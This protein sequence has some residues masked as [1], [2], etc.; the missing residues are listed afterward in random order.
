MNI[1]NII[2]RVFLKERASS[3]EYIKYL[4][5]LGVEIGEDCDIFVPTKTVIDV[6]NPWMLKI[7]DY[8]RITDGVK[9]LTHDYSWS[10]LKR[11]ESDS[12]NNGRILGAIGPVEIGNNVF[13]GM[14]AIITR[15]VKIGD[16]VII[17]AGSIVTHDCESNSVYAGNPA[18]RIMS[19]EEYYKKRVKLQLDEAVKIARYYQKRNGKKPPRTIFAEYCMLFSEWDD[20]K[21]EQA[22]FEKANLCSN[23][24]ATQSYIDTHK[25]M[26]N[27]YEEFLEYCFENSH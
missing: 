27:S 17:G 26:F 2:K 23:I 22:F 9:I 3:Q 5:K 4:R 10:V 21:K 12:E 13:I 16:N 7:G 25:P 11:L 14:N 18:K 15:N 8:V 20:V 19:I 1:K 24:E 6:Q